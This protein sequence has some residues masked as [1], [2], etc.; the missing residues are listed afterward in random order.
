MSPDTQTSNAEDLRKSLIDIA[1][2][3]W[4]Q[5]RLLESLLSKLSADDQRRYQGKV[6]WFGRRMEE[7][8]AAVGLKLVSIEGH[9]FA[10]G[11]AAT[12][13]N[14]DEYHPDD[15]LVV[16]RMLEPIIMGSEGLVRAG[17]V[18]LRKVEA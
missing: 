1:V 15:L 5:G 13:L 11:I 17:T 7:S 14:L 2:E 3:S 8:L 12:P 4:Q 9:P 18:T 16:D 10:P 6:R